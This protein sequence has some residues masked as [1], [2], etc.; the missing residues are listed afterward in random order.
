MNR[1]T[2]KPPTE[3]ESVTGRKNS[4]EQSVQDRPSGNYAR[5]GRVAHVSEI[6][7]IT[8]DL[9]ADATDCEVKHGR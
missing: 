5:L 2:R 9:D 8:L 6:L 3:C 4:C 1:P 7:S